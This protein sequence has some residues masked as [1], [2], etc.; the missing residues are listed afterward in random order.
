MSKTASRVAGIVIS[1]LLAVFLA[2]DCLTKI[3]GVE[4]SR[5]G[6]AELGFPV[7][8]T[9]VIGWVLLAC[10]VVFLI[11]RTA[12]LGA[13]GITAYL[14]GAVTANMRVEKHVATFVLSAV[15]VSVLLWIGLVLRP[16]EL[17]RVLG[18]RGRA[19]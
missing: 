16:P 7:G 2:F 12:V 10:L 17:L 5:K 11:P 9:A 3:L 14:G 6:T 13:I 15:Y 19:D 1:A 8:Q 4:A 18:L